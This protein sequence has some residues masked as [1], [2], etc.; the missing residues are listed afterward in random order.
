LENPKLT[1]D[2]LRQIEQMTFQ[3][4]LELRGGL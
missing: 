2:E 4:L 3:Q 1:L